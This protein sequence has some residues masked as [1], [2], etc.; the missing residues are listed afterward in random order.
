MDAKVWKMGGMG[1]CYSM[2]PEFQSSKVKVMRDLLYDNMHTVNNTVVYMQ[3]F[4]K[5][6]DFMLCVLF[7]F[8][9]FITIKTL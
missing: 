2:G 9:F 6:V 3:N 7:L 8:L 1:S 5:R 4:V